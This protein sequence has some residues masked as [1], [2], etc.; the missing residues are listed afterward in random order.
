MTLRQCEQNDIVKTILKNQS[1]KT[2]ET[3]L[4]WF[5]EDVSPL[6]LEAELKKPL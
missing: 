6:T 5:L 1:V 3:G 4:T 2:E